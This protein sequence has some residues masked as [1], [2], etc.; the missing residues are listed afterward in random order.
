MEHVEGYMRDLGRRVR[1]RPFF[2]LESAPG[3]SSEGALLY[4]VRSRPSAEVR[5]GRNG[6]E[7][8]SGYP[9]MDTYLTF[10]DPSGQERLPAV[11]VSAD[12]G[13]TNRDLPK[14]LK[15]GD[16]SVPTT[17]LPGSS[18][19]SYL[20]VESCVANLRETP[21]RRGGRATERSCLSG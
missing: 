5:N 15:L 12:L 16:I 4:Q 14:R 1:L 6:R 9:G 3:A 18:L 20:R 10:V 21:R 17:S 13:V 2:D 8:A 19:S 7:R 11:F